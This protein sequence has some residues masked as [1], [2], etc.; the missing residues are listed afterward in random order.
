MQ[1]LL[2]KYSSAGGEL[3]FY[4]SYE[5][6]TFPWAFLTGKKI[7]KEVLLF[8]LMNNIPQGHGEGSEMQKLLKSLQVA[9]WGSP[10][11]FC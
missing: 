7:L 11:S 4:F 8:S 3:P 6:T 1:P 2:F 10:V 5:Y 9:L